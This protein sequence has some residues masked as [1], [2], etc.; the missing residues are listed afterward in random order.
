MQSNAECTVSCCPI[1]SW[2]THC[3]TNEKFIFRSAADTTVS[4]VV[5]GNGVEPTAIDAS[6]SNTGGESLA[7]L[8]NVDSCI[9]DVGSP[10]TLE[11][12]ISGNATDMIWL[13]NGKELKSGDGVEFE[14]ISSLYRLSIS[15][16]SVDDSGSYQFEARQGSTTLISAGSI[17][18]NGM[19]QQMS[20]VHSSFQIQ[21]IPSYRS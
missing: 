2:S 15:N 16:A 4:E 9:V 17:I 6:P 12:S 18:V 3:R 20:I 14:T 11:A 5:E 19:W 1:S 7:L 21:T 8:R 10:V 13:K